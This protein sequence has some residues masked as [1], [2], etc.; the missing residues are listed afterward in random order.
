[1]NAPRL[2]V[3]VSSHRSAQSLMPGLQQSRFAL[4]HHCLE[5]AQLHEAIDAG[6]VDVALVSTG[7]RGL[8]AAALAALARRQVPLVVLD[9]QPYHQRWANFAG[10][11]LAT[12]ASV[13]MVVSGLE[14]ALRGERLREPIERAEAASALPEAW[15]RRCGRVHRRTARR[16]CRRRRHHHHRVGRPRC[17]RPLHAWRSIWPRYSAAWRP[18][19][20]STPTWARPCSP[21]AL[22]P[23]PTRT[24]SP[25]P[26]R[27]QVPPRNGRTCSVAT[28]SRSAQ[29]ACHRHC[30]WLG[31]P[32]RTRSSGTAF[33]TGCSTRCG[34]AS[35][36]SSATPVSG[37]WMAIGSRACRFKP[38][39]RCS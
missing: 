11:V 12:D 16:D 22:G 8:D 29:T 17:A 38:R 36:T 2:A 30:S 31:C 15:I 5:P 1:M 6:A 34:L 14:A 28:C 24:W 20:W 10:V 7:P 3:L 35:T 27:R 13:D 19:C 4:T 21:R 33:S 32:E 25:S 26:T 37:G 23:T 9:S 39:T 18:R